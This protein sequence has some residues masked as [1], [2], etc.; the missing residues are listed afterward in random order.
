MRSTPVLTWGVFR[1]SESAARWTALPSPLHDVW[2]IVPH[3]D[4]SGVIF[5]TNGNG[6]PGNTGRLLM[7]R[8]HG[9]HW[10][11]PALPATFILPL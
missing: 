2:A 3:A 6:P 9:A 7:S 8:D 5:L 11:E 4:H 10:E 1:W